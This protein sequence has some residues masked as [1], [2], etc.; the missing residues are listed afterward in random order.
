MAANWMRRTALVAACASAALLAACGSSSIESALKPEQLITFGDGY[1]FVREQRYTV[2]NGTVNNWTLQLLD[3]YQKSGSATGG[4]VSFAE[5]NTRIAQ[6][7][8]AAG[9]A[10]TPTITEQVDRFLAMGTPKPNDLLLLNGGISDLIV[11]MAAVRAGT[12][13]PDQF[14]ANARL[15]GQALAAQVRRLVA[16]GA[17]H[18][19]VTG[20]YDLG[21]TPW[22]KS[23]GQE[24]LLSQ[25]SSRFNEALLVALND[26]SQHVLYVDA[27]YYV[28]LYE[29]TP[30]SF[31]FNNATTPVC[32]S[33]DAGN[34]IG[35]GQGQVN[36]ALCTSATL[37]PGADADRYVFADAV[38]LTP[39]AH[40]QLGTY[41]YDKLR[42]RW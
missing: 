24:A 25:A 2:N 4:L 3:H 35:I 31:S 30:S 1:S 20:T 5:G 28:N 10:T 12:Q 11:G 7:P 16:A 8:D 41:A 38:Y 36:S 26:L 32:T 22:A 27:A 34:G 29:S 21:K 39:S 17:S 37:L 19:A 23:I 14:V 40:R 42:A 9:N 18:I 6:H 15:N 13:T 33:V